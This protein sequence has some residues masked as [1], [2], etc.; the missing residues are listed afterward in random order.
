MKDLTVLYPI[1]NRQPSN[2]YGLLPYASEIRSIHILDSS[3]TAIDIVDLSG[4]FALSGVEI[5]YRYRPDLNL[6]EARSELLKTL[7]TD[8]GLWFDSDVIVKSIE[9]R[10][11]KSLL[12]EGAAFFCPSVVNSR[13]LHKPCGGEYE[14][15]KQFRDKPLVVDLMYS[16]QP[17]DTAI[18]GMYCL[19]FKNQGSGK[20]SEFFGEKFLNLLP[21]EDIAFCT[22]LRHTC[23]KS[24][25]IDLY[26]TV[27]HIGQTNHSAWSFINYRRV[28][29]MFEK[30]TCLEDLYSLIE[31]LSSPKHVSTAQEMY[32]SS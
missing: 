10:L 9:M 20:F 5:V 26:S 8:Y 30:S 12:N 23:K 2:L 13:K 24:G 1:K 25:V 27:F 21:S 15:L 28:E 4:V 18:A 29:G 22:Y 14:F 16:E 31:M 6:S 3:D 17:I 32:Q 11:G 19:M 7:N